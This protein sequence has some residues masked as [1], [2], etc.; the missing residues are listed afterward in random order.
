M[1]ICILDP[2]L[3]TQSGSPSTN[4]GDLIIQDAVNQEIGALF[5]DQTIYRCSTH[6]PMTGEQFAAIAKIPLI[7]VGGTNLLTSR[8]RPYNR[9]NEHFKCWSNQWA[10]H[11]LDAWRIRR[12]VLLGCGWVDYQGEPDIFTRLMY[13]TVLAKKGFHS[14]RD[15]YSKQKLNNAGISNVLNTNC[16]TMWNLLRKRME[17]IPTT[18]AESALVMLTDYRKDHTL[19]AQ[20]LQILVKRYRQV[21]AWPQ[22]TEDAAYLQELNF[23][24]V[25]LERTLE[26][27]DRFIQSDISFDYIGTRL[28]GGIRCLQNLRRALILEVDNRAREIA[29]DTGLPTTKRD[30]FEAIEAWIER[31]EPICLRLNE[32]AIQ[33]W[34][35]SVLSSVS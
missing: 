18:K 24:G 31:S 26:G 11:L 9:W 7:I 25:V 20:L 4:L 33:Q 28:H 22:G 17:T 5:P 29:Q 3:Q 6:E 30:N 23:S 2:G 34:R 35:E 1:T 16:V 21:Y 8:M 12:A 14:V 27:L 13:K 19:D 10:I 32:E 15:A